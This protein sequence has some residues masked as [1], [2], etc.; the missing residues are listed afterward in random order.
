VEFVLLIA[1]ALLARWLLDRTRSPGSGWPR[2]AAGAGGN[3]AETAVPQTNETTMA[4]TCWT[5]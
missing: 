2:P 4:A 3:V 1:I 5:R